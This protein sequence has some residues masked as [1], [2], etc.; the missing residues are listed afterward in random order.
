MA[1]TFAAAWCVSQLLLP[2]TCLEE[3]LQGGSSEPLPPLGFLGALQGH[4]T[5]IYALA[6]S[7]QGRLASGAKDGALSLWN[8]TSAVAGGSQSFSKTK[9][10]KGH[11]KGITALA[12]APDPDGASELLISGSADNTSRIWDASSGKLLQVI[13]HPRTVFGVAA[14]PRQKASESVELAT[15]CWDGVARTFGVNSGV[16]KAELVGH[17]GGLYAVA[18]SQFDHSLLA[19][20][21]ADRTVKIWD[22]DK[23]E[24]LWTLRGHGDHVTSV[25]WSPAA[26]V[27][28][29]ASGGWDRKFRLWEIPLQEVKACRETGQCS[30]DLVPRKV[31]RH[32]QLVWRVAFSPTGARV[33]ACHGAVGQS[34]TVVIYDVDTGRV[35]RRLGRHKDTP[36]TIAYSPSGHYLVSAGMDR[37]IHLY[38]AHALS[39]DMPQ[40]D[41]DDEEERMKWLQDIT[42]YRKELNG[43]LKVENESSAQGNESEATHP[44]MPHPMS[45]MAAFM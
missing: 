3:L 2:V 34:P 42:D 18:Y 38:D 44:W 37:K 22:V 25:D 8:L 36:L 5:A 26:G 16:P 33:A 27:P 9:K 43:T 23:G 39:D 40:G 20:A 30:A 7:E 11:S 28:V 17:Q 15:A 13:A 1:Y 10:F 31:A 45:G 29:L 6:I 19:T 24:L 21:S 14:R 12:F 35:V 4:K 41:L 32:P